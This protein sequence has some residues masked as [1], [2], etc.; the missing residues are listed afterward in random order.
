MLAWMKPAAFDYLAPS[1]IEDALAAKARGGDEAKFLAGG[2]S[3]VPAMNFRL[4]QPALLVDINGVAGLDGIDERDGELHLGAL[5]RHRSLLSDARIAQA[6][7][8][9]REAALQVA[10]P[11]VRNRGTLC[12]NLAHADPASELPAVMLALGARMR[13]R[14]VR[15]E[16][17]IAASDFFHGMFATA[18]EPDE[19]LAGVALPAMA[20]GSG[21]AFLE[22]SR[23]QGDFAM[24]G[25]AVVLTLGADGRC[26]TARIALC[27]AGPAPVLSAAASKAVQGSALAESDLNAAAA[28]VQADIDPLGSV[29]AGKPFQRHLA[30]V[31]VRRALLLAAQR[32]SAAAARA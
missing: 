18:L 17:W 25:V 4:A 13:A 16:R 30:G 14:S 7:P 10:H 8:L 23:R 9:V 24:M 26:A 2:Q 28:A 22:V 31:L 5:V 11:Q 32:A 29:H 21:T 20:P 15:G 1:T 27:N 12:G 6:Q 3:L 19:M